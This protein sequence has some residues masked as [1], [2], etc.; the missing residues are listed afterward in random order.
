M[1]HLLLKA[2]TTA[3]TDK[4][5]FTAIAAAYSVDRVKDRIIPGAFKSTIE[6]WQQSGK[7]IPLHW[8]HEGDPKSIIGSVNPHSMRE[9][10]QGLYVEGRV[11]LD[12]DTGREAW[13]SMKAGTMSL[14]FGYLVDKSR[15]ASEGVTELLSID[16]FEVSIVPVPAN[17]DTKILETKSADELR[18]MA[19]Q[20]EREEQDR[21]VASVGD[22]DLHLIEEESPLVKRVKDLAAEASE[23]KILAFARELAA[24]REPKPTKSAKELRNEA[25]AAIREQRQRWEDHIVDGVQSGQIDVKASIEHAKE[26]LVAQERFEPDE[27]AGIESGLL[28]AVWTTAYINDLPDSAFLYIES[29]G[30][31]D[32]EGKTTPRSLRHFPYKDANG[33]VDLPHLRNA[34]ARIPQSNLP[35]NVK[36]RLTARAQ[37][38][39][40]NSKSVDVTDKETVESRSV[41]PLR[42]QAEN[43][44]LEFASG[45]LSLRKSP[46]EKV[47]PKPTPELELAELKRRMHEE[48]VVHLR[49]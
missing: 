26:A 15:K 28:K 4:G 25:D 10:D 17:A 20:V 16:L 42:K 40:D 9:T 38:I 14:S 49:G 19:A 18:E 36:D 30:S 29:G 21:I 22:L 7:L 32:S 13:R 24:E 33:S 46:K 12:S 44:A 5:E 34:L 35:Q 31:K 3:T 23:D 2:A 47:Q 11:H 41:D 39:L 6:R 43:T 8:N 27:I 45:G 1:E 48:I 37:R